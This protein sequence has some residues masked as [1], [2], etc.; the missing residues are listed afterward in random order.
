MVG[1]G[2]EKAYAAAAKDRQRL[3][4]GRGR[5]GIEQKRDLNATKGCAV[6][7]AGAQVGVSGRLVSR[8][9]VVVAD[10]CPEL[11][12]AVRGGVRQL[13]SAIQMSVDNRV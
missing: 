9:K 10:G 5:K 12:Q 1:G 8:A 3:S 4:E 13:S 7:K 6:D 2:V 11:Q